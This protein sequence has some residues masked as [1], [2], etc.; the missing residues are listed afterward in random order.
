MRVARW[1]VPIALPASRGSKAENLAAFV[2]S[3]HC[4]GFGDPGQVVQLL[5]EPPLT[6][7]NLRSL[8][9]PR[10]NADESAIG[11]VPIGLAC[12]AHGLG[13]RFFSVRL[14]SGAC[15]PV[16]LMKHALAHWTGRG[17]PGPACRSASYHLSL[18]RPGS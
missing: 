17:I 3:L 13:I 9:T 10:S 15:V 4:C 8:R 14:L 1:Y 6:A 2:V 7:R 18:R 12:V 11:Y 16:S 5:T